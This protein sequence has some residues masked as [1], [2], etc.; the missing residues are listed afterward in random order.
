MRVCWRGD[1]QFF[2][3]SSVSPTTGECLFIGKL[4]N[5][6]DNLISPYIINPCNVDLI[7]INVLSSPFLLQGLVLFECGLESAHCILPAKTSLVWS[8]P[9]TGGK[10]QH[11]IHLLCHMLYTLT[12]VRQCNVCLL[13]YCYYTILWCIL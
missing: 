4:C 3:I 9:Y 10:I 13:L 2:A 6:T 11:F 1:G 8:M 12:W 5:S 7:L